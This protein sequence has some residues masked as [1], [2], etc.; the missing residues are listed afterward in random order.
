MSS[1]LCVS[2]TTKNNVSNEGTMIG[3]IVEEEGEGKTR[4][5]TDA[6]P[7]FSSPIRLH[8][9]ISCREGAWYESGQSERRA[10][11]EC[12]LSCGKHDWFLT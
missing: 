7:N 11:C 6:P 1:E 8:V 3:Q 12:L 10:R 4:A 9:A 2:S 5:M